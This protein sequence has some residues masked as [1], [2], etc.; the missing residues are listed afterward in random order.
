MDVCTSP[1]SSMQQ[2]SPQYQSVITSNS[3]S[4][5]FPLS[6]SH[7]DCIN[8]GLDQEEVVNDV[9]NERAALPPQERRNAT[10][11][12]AS[13]VHFSFLGSLCKMEQGSDD[14][15]RL[16]RLCNMNLNTG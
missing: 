15:T 4:L 9:Q 13:W 10:C 3:L 8:Q 1:K 16:F 12:S 6:L 2:P 11:F 7:T 5:F 14:L